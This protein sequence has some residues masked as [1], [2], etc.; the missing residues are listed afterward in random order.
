MSSEIHVLDCLPA[1]AL[2]SLDAGEKVQVEEHL[3]GCAQC[4]REL[5]AY[6][7]VVEE[8]PLATPLA[9]PPPRLRQAILDRAS[10]TVQKADHPAKRSDHLSLLDRLRKSLSAPVPTWGLV[11][12]LVV[13]V[14]LLAINLILLQRTT[15]APAGDFRVVHLTGTTFAQE[16]SA[17]VVMSGDGQAGTLITEWLPALPSDK[18]YQ[19]WLV[20]DGKRKSGGVFSVDEH[21]Y[22][23]LWVYTSEP[24]SD[25]KQFGVTI[26][27]LGGS[28]GPTGNKVLGGSL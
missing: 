23:S 11:G 9:D 15:A 26:E 20:K 4:Q 7:V 16:A 27:P 13:V 19:L 22:A 28:P 12:A 14:A 10:Q 25:Y 24:L 5:E 18:Q 8:L 3:K 21:G 1:Y 17:W 6:R 2:G